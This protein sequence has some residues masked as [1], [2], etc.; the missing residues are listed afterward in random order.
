MTNI[1]GEDVSQYDGDASGLLV[2]LS[3]FTVAA[4]QGPA[5]VEV[6]PDGNHDTSQ[7]RAYWP[8]SPR[9]NQPAFPNTTSG[10]MGHSRPRVRLR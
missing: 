2:P 7:T 6:S 4:G 3:P 1:G 10:R 8:T 5:G 9:T